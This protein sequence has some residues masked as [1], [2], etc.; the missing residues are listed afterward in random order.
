MPNSEVEKTERRSA[1]IFLKGSSTNNQVK[2]A[3]QK[4]LTR[5]IDN[6]NT[7]GFPSEKILADEKTR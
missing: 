1:L 7:L 6:R 5:Q 3:K 2:Y 4:E